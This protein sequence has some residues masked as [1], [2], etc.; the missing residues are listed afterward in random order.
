MNVIQASAWF[1]PDSFG[2]VEV[3]LDGLVEDLRTIDLNCKVAAARNQSQ[4]TVEQYN[5]T[6]VFRYPNLET[7]QAWL[8]ENQSDI[9]H[10]HTLRSSCGLPHLQ[11]AKQ[12]GMKTIVTVHMPDVSCLRGTM[13]QGGNSACD[14]KIEIDRCSACLGVSKRVPSWV[15]ETLSDLPNSIADSMRDRLRHS[16]DVRLRQLGT[17]IATPSQIRHHQRQFDQMVELSDRIVVVCQWLYDAFV[18]NGVPESKLLLSRHGVVNSA[19]PIQKSVNFPIRIGFLGRWQETKGVQILAQ[20]LQQIPN[21]PVELVIHA[22]H[23][24]QHGNENRE[25]VLAI[26]QNDSRIQI[27]PPLTRS[28]ISD[29]IAQFD[30]LAV[31]SQWMETGPLVVL[32]SFAMRTPVIGSDLGGIAELVKHK[33]DGWLVPAKDVNEWAKA[34]AFL[35]ENP[36]TIAQLKQNIQPVKTRVRVAAEMFEL[37]QSLM[38][39]S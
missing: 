38:R 6:E 19:Q 4:P 7:F 30:L 32:E 5:A 39:E 3:Y 34:I 28:Q 2:G 14:G 35:V 33:V 1:P 27:K 36:S 24:D 18:L 9:Y 37:Y 11:S 8:R 26:A 22:T 20:A 29:A 23:A 21:V 31:P 17:T 10:Q 25:N 16:S 12:L 13:M 15:T